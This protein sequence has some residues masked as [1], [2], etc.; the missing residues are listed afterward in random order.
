MEYFSNFI[1]YNRDRSQRSN[2]FEIK[3]R[4]TSES[5]LLLLQ[6]KTYTVEGDYLTLAL[7][8][9]HVEA[10]YNLGKETPDKPLVIRSN[11]KVT[12]GKWHTVK[13]TR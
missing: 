11:V 13:F 9:G 1:F 5:G 2:K 6:H 8:E 10:S 12:D 3:F 4:T 7:R